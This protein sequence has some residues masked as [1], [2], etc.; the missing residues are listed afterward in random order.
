M[1]ESEFQ[2]RVLD[3]MLLEVVACPTCHG[4]L[5]LSV[6]RSALVCA[7]C[8]VSYPIQDGVPVLL[9]DEARPLDP[10]ADGGDED[11]DRT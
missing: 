5:D 7:R 9:T 2:E 6:D 10:A 3:P 4:G 1:S 8:R 11:D